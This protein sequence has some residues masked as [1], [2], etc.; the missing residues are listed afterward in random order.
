MNAETDR[1]LIDFVEGEISL[2][3]L[4]KIISQNKSLE[5]SIRSA[6][7][8]PPYSSLSE[9]LFDYLTQLSPE[10]SESGINAQ[11]AICQL[12][13]LRGINFKKSDIYESLFNLK[14]K[15]EPK[16]LDIDD[17]Y[18]MEILNS[19]K[20]E[21]EKGVSGRLKKEILSKFKYTDKP[22]KWLQSPQWPIRNNVPL[23][24]LKQTKNNSLHD[25]A[26][27]YIFI[28]EDTG[29]MEVV[30]QSA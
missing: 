22:P 26:Y 7:P 6:P 23:K 28:N 10:G 15:V 20:K 16:W 5:E 11:D 9:D 24:F 30:T 17:R 21:G 4:Q 19:V 27:D 18:F 25:E 8:I 14:A 1:P 2:H 29:V 13:D 3:A 12:L